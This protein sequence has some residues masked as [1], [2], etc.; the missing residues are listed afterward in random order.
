MQLILMRVLLVIMLTNE[1]KKFL[2]LSLFDVINLLKFNLHVIS[3]KLK[4]SPASH[5][6]ILL[7]FTKGFHRLVKSTPGGI[8]FL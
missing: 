7:I 3:D 5:L 2:I 8:S 1:K 6:R 4:R